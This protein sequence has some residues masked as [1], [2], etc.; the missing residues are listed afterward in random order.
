MKIRI[1]RRLCRNLTRLW[2]M[3]HRVTKFM[4]AGVYDCFV[5]ARC[6][7]ENYSLRNSSIQIDRIKFLDRSCWS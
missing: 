2:S 5:E 6:M 4:M 1:V 3:E 7:H